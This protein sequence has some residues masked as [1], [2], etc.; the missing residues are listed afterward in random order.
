M[1]SGS[2]AANNGINEGY[3]IQIKAKSNSDKD[4]ENAIISIRNGVGD[5]TFKK[6][7]QATEE[8]FKNK[9][10]ILIHNSSRNKAQDMELFDFS[11]DKHFESLSED[12]KSLVS[13]KNLNL[14]N[15]RS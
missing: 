9:N 8:Q 1:I 3:I 4:L 7:S 6:D 10:R 13:I 12:V 2:V 5:I 15:G 11:K 14:D